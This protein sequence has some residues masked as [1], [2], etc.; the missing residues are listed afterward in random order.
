VAA[1]EDPDKRNAGRGLDLLRKGG[2][3]VK[4]GVLRGEA[5]IQNRAFLKHRR[6]GLPYVLWKSAQTLDGKIASRTGVSKWITG[7]SARSLGHVL[8]AQS[9]AVMVGA[10]TVR[11]DD[12]ALTAHGAGPDPLRIVVSSSLRLPP[13]SNIFR[14]TPA[15]VVSARESSTLSK[16]GVTGIVVPRRG[17]GLDLP[18]AFRRL[19]EAGIT[20]ILL[21][22]GGTLAAACLEAGL[23]DEAYLF[24]AP[25]FLGGTGARPSLGGRGWA[26]PADGP[27]L[28]DVSVRPVGDDILIHGMVR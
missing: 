22:G 1:L 7:A 17:D 21:E 18:A 13:S 3:A 14:G 25:R 28:R 16:K 19:G 5:E 20:R 12:P 11:R 2:V 6:T 4:V 27:A 8:R 15:W 9:D 10:E 26:S 23:I 24:V